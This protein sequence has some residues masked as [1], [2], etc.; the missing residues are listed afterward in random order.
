MLAEA[1]VIPMVEV[2]VGW[3]EVGG[4]K[5]NVIKDSLGMAIGLAILRVGW[6]VGWYKRD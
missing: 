1:A 4:S 5:L 6:G 2:P 3:K